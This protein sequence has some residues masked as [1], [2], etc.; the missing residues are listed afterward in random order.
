[1][2]KSERIAFSILRSLIIFSIFL[3]GI[4]FSESD[5]LEDSE[6]DEYFFLCFLVFLVCLLAD[7][8]LSCSCVVS[9]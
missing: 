2:N 4:S 8:G 7:Y 5:E 1:M 6:L 9:Y 3:I